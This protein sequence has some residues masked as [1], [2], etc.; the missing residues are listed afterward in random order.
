MKEKLNPW[1]APAPAPGPELHYATMNFATL[2]ALTDD[3]EEVPLVESETSLTNSRDR[4]TSSTMGESVEDIETHKMGDAQTQTTPETGDAVAKILA[5]IQQEFQGFKAWKLSAEPELNNLR[6][7]KETAT[8]TMAQQAKEIE[9]LVT[10]QEKAMEHSRLTR[11]TFFLTQ[12]RDFCNPTKRV[13]PQSPSSFVNKDPK[14]TFSP[15]MAADMINLSNMRKHNPQLIGDMDLYKAMKNPTYELH[16]L[17]RKF[18]Q[19]MKYS[20]CFSGEQL[21]AHKAGKLYH[22]PTTGNAIIASTNKV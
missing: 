21:H 15:E 3:T 19:F 20:Y 5:D 12:L 14:I 11:S 8:G 13:R 18:N 16:D 17:L 9:Y 6:V 10:E 2:P 7:F 4:P 22:T 1:I